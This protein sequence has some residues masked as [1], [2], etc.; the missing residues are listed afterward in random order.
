MVSEYK[1]IENKENTRTLNEFTCKLGKKDLNRIR[2]ILISE[3]E[4][5]KNRR[6]LE[7]FISKPENKK[8][9]RILNQLISKQENKE[10]IRILESFITKSENKEKIRILS[11]FISKPEYEGEI[12]KLNQLISEQENK[13]KIRTLEAFI[14]K[15]G[16]I[17][18]KYIK[19]KEE[20]ECTAKIDEKEQEYRTKTFYRGQS[21]IEYVLEP[22]IFRE[23][24][25]EKEHEIYLKVLSESSNEFNRDMTHID[26]LSKMQHYGVPTR[27][28]DVTTNPLVALYFAC[29][30]EKNKDKDGKIFI[31]KPQKEEIKSFDSDTIAILAS[32]PRFDIDEKEEL[33]EDTQECDIEKFNNRKQVKRLLHEIK[34]ENSAFENI[35]DPKDLLKN[36]F[37]LP[38]K[39]NS[40]IIRQN[41]AFIIFGLEDK[42]IESYEEIIISADS[43]EEILRQL[44]Y[45]G[46]TKASLHPELYKM[47]EYINDCIKRGVGIL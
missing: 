37:L 19:D 20:K 21:N 41:G 35:I 26:K 33:K 3:Q 32:L 8:N 15:L 4:N 44:E 42:K 39:D 43:K 28:L 40:R 18:E 31:F 6:T 46:I 5:E 27:L 29:D 47:S 45:C 34:K 10:K 24:R 38:K 22:S 17:E 11:Q 12:R 30:D 1:K 7:V 16:N 23:N 13:E 14:T 36:Y 25:E 9:I 2:E